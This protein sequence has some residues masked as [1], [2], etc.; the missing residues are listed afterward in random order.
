MCNIDLFICK[1]VTVYVECSHDLA[2][3]QFVCFFR[4]T[5]DYVAPI[6]NYNKSLTLEKKK[7]T[8]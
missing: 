2:L 5:K 8:K 6:E 4:K 7:G 3:V 1:S